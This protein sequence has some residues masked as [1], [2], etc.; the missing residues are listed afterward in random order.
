VPLALLPDWAQRLADVLPFKW[1]FGYPIEALIG[2]LPE[3]DLLGGLA[4]QLAWIVVG[5]IG[6]RVVWRIAIRRYSAVN[7]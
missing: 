3:G 7:G 4:I 2:R 1:T 6:V 5:W